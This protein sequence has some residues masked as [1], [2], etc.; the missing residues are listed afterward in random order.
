M[1]IDDKDFQELLKHMHD[2]SFKN[3]PD[4]SVRPVQSGTRSPFV[5]IKTP[6]TGVEPKIKKK[7]SSM[8]SLVF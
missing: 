8:A 6:K 3:G 4:R 5:P 7:N 2:H 1:K